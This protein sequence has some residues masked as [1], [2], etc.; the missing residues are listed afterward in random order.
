MSYPRIVESND[1]KFVEVN[2]ATIGDRSYLKLKGFI[3]HSS[4][5][6]LRTEIK[7][8]SDGSLVLI[9]LTPA[10]KSSSGRFEILVPMDSHDQKVLFGSSKV[11]IWPHVK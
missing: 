11:Q 9:Y 7:Q 1:V 3:F 10:S 2:Y 6:V 8:E 5:A 4:L